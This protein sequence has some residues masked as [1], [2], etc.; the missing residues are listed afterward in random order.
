MNHNPEILFNRLATWASVRSYLSGSPQRGT[1]LYNDPQPIVGLLVPALELLEAA[2]EPEPAAE[3][4]AAE[5]GD[6]PAG[7]SSL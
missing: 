3:D 4:P 1:R 6:D 2:P 7:D 5:E